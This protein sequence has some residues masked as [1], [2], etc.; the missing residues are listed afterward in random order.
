MTATRG[1]RSADP[2]IAMLGRQN[3]GKSSLFNRIVEERRA[4]V[5]AIAGTTRDRNTTSFTWRG[6]SL[7]LTD[8]GGLGADAAHA[9]TAGV[10]AQAIRAAGDADCVFFV[11]DGKTGLT[12]EDEAALAAV[13]RLGKPLVIV[14]NKIDG[15]RDRRAL[16]PELARLGS[17]VFLVSAKNGSGVGDLLDRA[18]ELLAGTAKVEDALCTL[19]LFGKPNVGKS[20]LMNALAGEERALVHDAPHTT[21]DPLAHVLVHNGT[22]IRLV[23]TAGVRRHVRL[24]RHRGKGGKQDD[25]ETASV[26]VGLRV[27]ESADVALLVLDGAEGVTAQDRKLAETLNAAKV[28]LVIV[29]NKSDLRAVER[30]T[31]AEFSIRRSLP[32]LGWAPLVFVSAKERKGMS[33]LLDLALAVHAAHAAELPNEDCQEFLRTFLGRVKPPR[34]GRGKPVRIT[35]LRQTGTHPPTFHV[36]VASRTPLA[37]GYIRAFENALREH[38]GLFGTPLNVTFDS[39]RR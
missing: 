9:L 11:V 28:G 2:T 7:L 4:I 12:S 6:R 35:K 29:V 13:R 38:F 5:S 16:P 8:T 3:V 18:A 33:R 17:D 21:R 24:D 36:A 39:S 19:A 34:D 1:T 31:A 15:S 20:S 14:V 22:A 26:A 32:F 30:P 25:L 10:T 37:I 27:L 23:D